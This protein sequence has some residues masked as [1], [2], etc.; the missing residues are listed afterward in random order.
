[1]GS[2]RGLM[3]RRPKMRADHPHG[4]LLIDKPKGCSSFDVLR[5]LKRTHRLS[6]LGHT[7]TLDPMATGL[8]VVCVGEGTKLAHYLTEDHKRYRAEVH[9]SHST[10]SYDAEGSLVERASAAQRESLSLE[11]VTGALRGFLGEVT[12]RPP[13]FSA[14]KVNGE[15]LY[16]KARR[17]EEVEVPERLVTFHSI[18]LIDFDGERAQLDVWCSKG[19]YIRSL[20][21]DL[22]VTLGCPAHLSALRRTAC[23][24]LL[25]SEAVSL[26]ALTSERLSEALCPLHEALPQWPRVWVDEQGAQELAQGRQAT[27]LSVDPPRAPLDL[28]LSSTGQSE[29]RLVCA[30]QRSSSP[31]EGDSALRLV[32]VARLNPS[33]NELQVVRG[34]RLP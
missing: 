7:G 23:G 32:A 29:T 19:T 27:A 6:K 25:L 17:G 22:G 14:I 34:L 31:G 33:G 16:A 26:E 30:V 12:Q 1:M 28:D 4:I 5:D 9:F 15:R 20:A 13:A 8:L 21:H 2:E 11:R 3:G 18:E 24:G 10:D